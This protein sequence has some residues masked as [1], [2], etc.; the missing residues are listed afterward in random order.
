MRPGACAGAAGAALGARRSVGRRASRATPGPGSPRPAPRRRCVP[1]GSSPV[2][3]ARVEAQVALGH[4]ADALGGESGDGLVVAGLRLQVPHGGLVVAQLA[5]QAL[6]RLALVDGL[7]LD[8]GL[9]RGQLVRGHQARAQRRQHAHRLLERLRQLLVRQG[10]RGGEEA[11]VL[12][13]V[14]VGVDVVDEAPLAL[15]LQHQAARRRPGRRAWPAR[16]ARARPGGPPGG[17]GR[18]G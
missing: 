2:T 17:W 15:H 12:R 3:M 16:R 9:H 6:H 14:G 7:G 18:R 8:E 5:R 11:R 4:L 10:E 13:G 1:G